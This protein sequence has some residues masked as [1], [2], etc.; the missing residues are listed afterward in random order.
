MLEILFTIVAVFYFL[1]VAWDM[2]RN[3]SCIS[4]REVGV[5]ALPVL[6]LTA[7]AVVDLTT[8]D[9]CGKMMRLASYLLLSDV[10][11]ICTP[12]S[13]VKSTGVMIC[14][15]TAIL[16]LAVFLLFR[17]GGYLPAMA[18]VAIPWKPR[19]FFP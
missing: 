18:D 19:W 14:L 10:V 2:L 8:G 7:L 17:A 5:K 13:F 6:L 4:M 15:W 16:F 3:R 9:S 12:D 11:V 1:L